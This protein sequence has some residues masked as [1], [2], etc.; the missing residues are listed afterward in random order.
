MGPARTPCQ[1]YWHG[2]GAMPA[3]HLVSRANVGRLQAFG[4]G[5]DIKS[6]ALTFGQGLETLALDCGKM[7]EKIVTAAFGGDETKALGLVEPLH[8]TCCHNLNFLKQNK[9]GASPGWGEVKM[10][11]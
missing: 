9:N 8:N 11:G 10:A 4:A 6:N 5:G 7:G 1:D 3:C 2:R